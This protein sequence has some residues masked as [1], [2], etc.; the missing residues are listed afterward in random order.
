AIAFGKSTA[1]W[2]E[3]APDAPPHHEE[4][5]PLAHYRP[6]AHFYGANR[7]RKGAGRM[8][9]SE[10]RKIGVSIEL[11]PHAYD[12]DS[13]PELFEG[14]LARRVVAFFIDIFIVIAPI[15]LAAIFILVFGLLTFG[16]GLVLFWFLS[17]ATIIWALVYY[18]ATLGSPASATMGMRAME[19]EMRTWYG[20][21]S[22][23]LL[24]AVHVIAFWIS[25][26]AL[27]PL[28]LLVPFFNKR[29]RL[30]HD[31]VVGAIIINNAGRAATLK[32]DRQAF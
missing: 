13:M 10:P 28:V 27:T 22:Y 9:E 7:Q 20:A 4:L 8:P 24:G 18:G 15:V 2:F 16:L 3:T 29:R 25:V 12:P 17:P 30:L 5:R 14:V 6:C 31:M 1:S 19:I 11:K 23:S 32:A 21:P 26:S